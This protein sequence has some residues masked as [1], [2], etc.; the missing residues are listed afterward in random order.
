MSHA[1]TVTLHHPNLSPVQRQVVEAQYRQALEQTLGGADA[2]LRAWRAW[3]EAEHKLG[4]LSE[5]TW[6][7]ARQWLIAA[8]QARR[9]ALLEPDASEVYFEVQSLQ[10]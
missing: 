7:V 6:K 2:V 5:D 1:Y 10:H 4:S 9:T 8:E 3:Q